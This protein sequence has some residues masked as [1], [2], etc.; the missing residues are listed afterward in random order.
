MYCRGLGLR[1]LSTFQD[2][3]DFD[4]I[5]VGAPEADYHLEFTR[6]RRH[7][8][9]PRPTPED[10][11]VFYYPSHEEWRLACAQMDAA[12]FRTVGSFNPYWAARGRSYQ[13]ADGYRVVLQQALWTSGI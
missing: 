1:I 5:M 10:L 3:D 12:G 7:P 6:S 9:T 11:L 2:H 4:G 13:D 8:I